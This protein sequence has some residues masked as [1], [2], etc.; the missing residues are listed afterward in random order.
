MDKLNHVGIEAILET[1]QQACSQDPTILKPAEQRLYSWQAH[2]GF[3][4]ALMQIFS[5]RS[6]DVNIR[7]LAI[8]FIKNGVDRYWRKNAPNAIPED[9][10]AIMRRQL[11]ST[12]DEPVSQISI[13]IAVLISKIARIELQSWPELLPIVFEGVQNPAHLIQHRSLLVLN[14]IAKMLVSKRLASDRQLFRQAFLHSAFNKITQ[15]LECRKQLGLNEK[16]IE[17]VEKIAKLLS[18]C[19]L[20]TLDHHPLSFIPLVQQSLQFCATYLFSVETA[21]LGFES[22]LVQCCNIMKAILRCDCYRPPKEIKESTSQETLAVHQI[23]MS[24]FTPSVLSEIIHR[25]VMHFFLLKEEELDNWES[26]PE[27]YVN[28]EVGESWRYQLRPSTEVL[29]LTLFAEYRSTVTPTVVNMIHS[30]QASPDSEDMTVLLQKDAVYTAAGLASYDLF[31]EV[32]FDKWFSER[33]VRE[34]HTTSPRLKLLRRRVPWLISQWVNVKLSASVRP[35]LY[36][37]LIFLMRD[38]EDLVYMSASFT[39]LFNL[40]RQ[41]TECDTKMHVL[42]VLSMLIERIGAK[43]RPH[44]GLLTMYLP[45]LWQESEQ[46]NMLRCA[47][48]ATLTHLVQG[49]GA[50]SVNLYSFLLPIV[51]LSTD[52]TQ[53]PHVYLLE[54]GLELWKKTIENA[55][56]MTP[57]LLH[58]FNNMPSLLD[59]GSENLRICF[60]IID[61][62]VLLDGKEFLESFGPAVVHCCE[63]L[64]GS[65]KPEGGMIIAKV[66]ETIVKSFPVEGVQ[67]LQ[68]VLVKMFQLILFQE[69]EYTPLLVIYLCI[70]EEIILQNP[71]YFSSFIEN[72]AGITST[73]SVDLLGQFLDVCLDKLDC[74]TRLERRKL[75]VMALS[76]LL[77]INSKC[78]TDR[79]ALIL[80]AVV[81]VL[82]EIHRSEDGVHTDCLVLFMEDGVPSDDA[83]TESQSRKKKI[84]LADPVHRIPLWQFVGSKLNESQVAH[85][86]AVFQSCMEK[87]DSTVAE[88]LVSFIN[89]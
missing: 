26:D 3:Y 71:S 69:E 32:D 10:K 86:D 31:G 16:L 51:Q 65:I 18:K 13:Q 23:K 25:L 27:D 2:P 63:N 29:Y 28:E 22:F 7:W 21:G 76:S 80:D 89:H 67:L 74:M 37:S 39:S 66:M 82:H 59:F 77:P 70:F 58:L 78:V 88:Q 81:D 20:D 14:H 60:G 42:H 36:E 34:M 83:E 45:H 64:L 79:F 24:F 40:L 17:M 6:M 56:K 4:T 54:D 61:R 38:H 30:V 72:M 47:I 9:E 53:P 68:P 33:L 55:T 87:L 48:L 8:L 75:T 49:M 57:E 46:H 52:I 85:G 62:Y 15:F 73:Q 44:I 12:F 84:T 19:L 41:V 5:N 35:L 1:L 43:V 50:D 11:L